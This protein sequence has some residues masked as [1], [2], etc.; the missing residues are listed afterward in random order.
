[1]RPEI[2]LAFG[3]DAGVEIIYVV[4]EKVIIGFWVRW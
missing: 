1:M 4:T 2:R 3:Q